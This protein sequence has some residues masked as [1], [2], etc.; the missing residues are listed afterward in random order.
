M[1]C[2]VQKGECMKAWL[3]R[4][5]YEVGVNMNKM[6]KKA[7]FVDL[8]DSHLTIVTQKHTLHVCICFT[9]MCAYKIILNQWHLPKKI[10]I[11]S[12]S[13]K[14][15]VFSYDLLLW[16]MLEYIFILLPPQKK[17]HTHII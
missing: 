13:I 15:N 5:Y 1:I 17:V 14:Y 2:A 8:I 7:E 11:T 10:N 16:W 4:L 6:V 12:V 9:Y 3:F